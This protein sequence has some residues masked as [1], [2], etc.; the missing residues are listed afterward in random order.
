MPIFST[1]SKQKLATCDE[2]LQRL[3]NAVIRRY[4]CIV[5]QGHRSV[6]EQQ[7]LYAQGRTKPGP[8]VT[9]L[10]GVNKKGMHNYSPARAVDI[11]P[12][13]LDW[14]DLPRFIHFAGYVKGVADQLGIS[15]R[16]GGDWDSDNRQSD[17]RFRDFPHF[18][19][20]D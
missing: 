6:A 19:V 5:L 16:W 15:V 9:Q 11:A 20:H 8:V 13:P 10:D 2:R 7:A 17:E 1:A 14:N 3:F 12:Y 4:D 18:E